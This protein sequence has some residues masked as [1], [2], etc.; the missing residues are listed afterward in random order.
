[1][2]PTCA[3]SHHKTFPSR[4]ESPATFNPANQGPLPAWQGVYTCLLEPPGLPPAYPNHVAPH[5]VCAYSTY[6]SLFCPVCHSLDSPRRSFVIRLL[7]CGASSWTG[8]WRHLMSLHHCRSEGR[9]GLAASVTQVLTPGCRVAS[10][11]VFGVR[12]EGLAATFDGMVDDNTLW[13]CQS[14]P[15]PSQAE[16]LGNASHTTH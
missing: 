8:S 3:S 7:L 13:H 2:G 10:P 14:R 1:M 6:V 9:Q 15:V 4:P 11:S 16:R 5:H 12:V